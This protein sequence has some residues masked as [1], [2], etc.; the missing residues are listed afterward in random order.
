MVANI[1]KPILPILIGLEQSC[2]VKG[3]QIL[4]GIIIFHEGIYSLKITKKLGM[5]VKLDIDKAYDKLIWQYMGE[6]P[7]AFGFGRDTR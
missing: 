5:L 7:R 6:I 3:R 4:D 2:F 1:L